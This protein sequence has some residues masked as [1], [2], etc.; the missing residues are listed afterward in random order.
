MRAEDTMLVITFKAGPALSVSP[1]PVV[2]VIDGR[3][4]FRSANAA[5]KPCAIWVSPGEHLLMVVPHNAHRAFSLAFKKRLSIEP[6]SEARFRATLEQSANGL[7]IGRF[8]R[9]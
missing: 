8:D 1:V 2:V 7:S 5:A 9:E 6:G 4:V 3:E